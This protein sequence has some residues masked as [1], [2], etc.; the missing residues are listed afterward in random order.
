V[1]DLEPH[2]ADEVV[3]SLR[4]G[5]PP[6]RFVSSYSAGLDDFVAKVRRRHLDARSSRGRI[7][8]LSGSWGSGKTHLLRL[9]S[10]EAFDAGYLVSTIELN[11]DEAPFN[12]FEQV[13]FRIVRG[14]TSPGMYRDNDLRQASPFGEVL[15]RALVDQQ[16]PE[17]DISDTYARARAALLHANDVD[18]DFRRVVDKY[19]ETFNAKVDDP[20]VLEEERGRLLQWFS[21]EGTLAAYRRTYGVQKVVDRANAHL[22]LQSLSRFARHLGHR[23]VLVLMDEAEMAFATMQ[24][25]ALKQAHNNLLHLINGVEDSEGLVLVYAAVPD[26]YSDPQRGIQTY[27]ALA[28]R[29][30]SPE[31]HPPRALDRVWNIDAEQTEM[32]HYQSAARKLRDLYVAAYGDQDEDLGVPT[33]EALDAWVEA[34]VDEHPQYAQI[35]VWRV[36]MTALVRD[37]DDRAQGGAGKDAV[38]AHR[39]VHDELISD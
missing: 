4:S 2:H 5:V 24:K 34:L 9:L 28:Q 18:I 35:S 19:W 15:R 1:I 36:L 20:T 38:E 3:E 21:G 11:K 8:F 32:S 22:M 31:E 12:K 23:G 39:S 6:K 13:F 29:I 10:E 37:F 14:L 27:G 16:Q 30:G 26:F 17:E 7:R 33:G 25:N